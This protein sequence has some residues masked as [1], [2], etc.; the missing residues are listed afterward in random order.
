M[1]EII[2][3][4][5]LN[6]DRRRGVALLMVLLIIVAITILA[7]GFL[8]HTH[9]EL[10]CGSNT[11]LRLQMDQL[12]QSG[13][14]HA[15]GLILHP[16]DVPSSFWTTPSV[17]QQLVEGSRDYYDVN[18][19]PDT[20]HYLD[21]CTYT[22]QCEAYRKR[23]D[24][25]KTGGSCLAATLRLDPCI[26]LEVGALTTIWNGMK[27]YGD[28]YSRAGLINNGLIDGDVF[29]TSLGGTGPKTGQHYLQAPTLAW[30]PVT[31][32]Y[33]NLEYPVNI[34]M[35]SLPAGTYQPDAIWKSSGSA[36]ITGTVQIRGM[37]LV[38]G[39]LVIRAAAG[40]SR[41]MAAPNLP[42]LYVRG[43]LDIEDVTRLQIDGLVVVDQNVR[44][45][46]A[47]SNIRVTGGLFVKGI[48]D[49]SGAGATVTIVADPMKA[50]I[51]LWE[52]GQPTQPWSPAAGAFYRSLRRE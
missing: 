28:V 10:A 9:A 6:T 52:G 51:V 4:S 35:G 24:G 42:A 50:A 33:A 30:P 5:R 13:L 23:P 40:D 43:N 3:E 31:A 49:P 1:L 21:Y 34:V 25:Q 38:D 20:S 44:L 26:A 22:I 37:L 36:E 48:V 15:R 19:V 11:L 7:T 14:D 27:V 8:A 18:V 17:A 32:S 45:S 16:Q 47:A 12:A 39:D 41:L 29:A 2:H 46:A